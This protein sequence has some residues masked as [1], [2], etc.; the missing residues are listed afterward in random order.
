M[1]QSFDLFQRVKTNVQLVSIYYNRIGT[2]ISKKEN[3]TVYDVMLEGETESTLFLESE[4]LPISE[5]DK[6]IKILSKV[7]IKPVPPLD[8]MWHNKEG[9]LVCN[10]NSN[11]ESP[12]IYGVVFEDNKDEI[13][14][15]RRDEVEEII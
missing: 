3:K 5:E 9:V 10:F 8:N 1:S 15:F 14:Y 11:K 13:I 2:I 4:L 6:L 7:R 12:Y